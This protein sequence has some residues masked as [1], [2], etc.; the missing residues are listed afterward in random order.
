M[1]LQV[2]V[3]DHTPNRFDNRAESIRWAVFIVHMRGFA[4][5]ST[6]NEFDNRA[7]S[8][9]WAVSKRRFLHVRLLTEPIIRLRKHARGN[10]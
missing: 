6:S 4:D 5:F 8:V 2:L 10:M 3:C 1:K 7:E 9:R